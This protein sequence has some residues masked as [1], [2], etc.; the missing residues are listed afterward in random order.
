MAL[1][2]TAV[3]DLAFMALAAATFAARARLLAPSGPS[4]RLDAPAATPDAHP[5]SGA[6]L[7]PPS[8]VL[9][10]APA[11]LS[12]ASWSVGSSEIVAV[13]SQVHQTLT[14]VDSAASA[15]AESVDLGMLVGNV[16][17]APRHEQQRMAATL[18]VVRP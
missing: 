7:A 17:L 9:S 3:V 18:T 13:A 1:P 6:G 2:R 10:V 5:A 4:P 14:L 11:A 8:P 12:S 15:V 16:V